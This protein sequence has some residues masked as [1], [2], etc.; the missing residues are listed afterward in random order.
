M[1]RRAVIILAAGQG[2]R[3]KSDLHKV[4]HPLAGRP[5][6]E[7]LL[8]TVDGIQAERRVVVV[9]R[10]REQLESALAH[11]PLTLAL[12]EEQ[13]GTGHAVQQAEQALSGFEGDVLILYGD[14]PC[15]EGATL[16]R[17][18]ARLNADDQPAIVVLASRPKNPAAYG[19]V[20]LGEGDTVDRMVEYKDASE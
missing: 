16:E 20:I 17:M 5:M 15:I 14:T 3:M 1:N 6:L 11:H 2:T 10:G 8:D 18:S 4:L 13:K 9:G 12:Q 7:H 19:R